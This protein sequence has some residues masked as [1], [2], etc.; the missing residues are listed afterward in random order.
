MR[1]PV[2][3]VRWTRDTDGEQNLRSYS[4]VLVQ[5]QF[6]RGPPAASLPSVNTSTE[7]SLARASALVK[8]DNRSKTVCESIE[9]P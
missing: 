8:G 4:T 5:F 9:E 2:W 7:Y 6:R 3:V 1:I